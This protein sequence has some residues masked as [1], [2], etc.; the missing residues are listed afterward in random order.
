[1]AAGLPIVAQRASCIPGVVVDGQNGLLVRA[2]DASSMAASIVRL[3]M[4]EELF[5]TIS[6]TNREKAVAEFSWPSIGKKYE[7]LLHEALALTPPSAV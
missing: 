3:L 1:M 7:S 5:A 2:N 4:D 6:N